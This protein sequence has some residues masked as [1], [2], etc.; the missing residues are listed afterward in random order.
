VIAVHIEQASLSRGSVMMFKDYGGR[1]CMA[2]DPA[3]TDEASAL[4][5]LRAR[6]PRLVD[7]RA[8]RVGA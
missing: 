6:V 7:D 1:V 2:Y 3:Q 5:L 4:A 8:H